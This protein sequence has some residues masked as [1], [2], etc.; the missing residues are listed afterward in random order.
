MNNN[1]TTRTEMIYRRTVDNHIVQVISFRKDP[2]YEDDLFVRV[3][4]EDGVFRGEEW[5]QVSRF[6]WRNVSKGWIKVK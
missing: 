3:L 2:K 5:I 1:Q 4:K 6:D